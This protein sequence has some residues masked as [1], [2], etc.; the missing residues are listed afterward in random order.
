VTFDAVEG[1]HYADLA[2]LENGFAEGWTTG[3]DVYGSV[4]VVKVSASAAKQISA[5]R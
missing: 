5:S 3:T 4:T 2:Q 1:R